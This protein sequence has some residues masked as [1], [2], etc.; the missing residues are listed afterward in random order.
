[1][2][3]SNTKD[4]IAELRRRIRSNKG[5]AQRA[6]D[7]AMLLR[8]KAHEAEKQVRRDQDEI[9]SMGGRVNR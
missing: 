8:M 3:I 1:M 7:S 6:H 9:V 2:T 4:R 5:I